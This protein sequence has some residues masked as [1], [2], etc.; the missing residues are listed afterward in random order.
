MCEKK[1]A[2]IDGGG[3]KVTKEPL[4]KYAAYKERKKRR[5]YIWEFSGSEARKKT[6]RQLD[7]A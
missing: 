3:A 6:I 2:A 5:N 4:T 1:S 7:G